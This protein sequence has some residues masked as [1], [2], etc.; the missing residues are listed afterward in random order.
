MNVQGSRIRFVLGCVIP[1][2]GAV[3]RSCNLGQALFGSPVRVSDVGKLQEAPRL[4]VEASYGRKS[5]FLVRKWYITAVRGNF[6][7][8]TVKGKFRFNL[9]VV[10]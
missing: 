4:V 10:P 2:A 3:A 8:K 5:L 9:T 7:G 1:R 6:A